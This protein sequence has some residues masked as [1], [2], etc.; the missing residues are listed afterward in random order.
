MASV[1]KVILIGNLGA[2][3]ELRE[4]KSGSVCTIS[5]ATTDTWFDKASNSKKERTEWH[6][7]IVWGK[8][9]ENVHKYLRK[10]SSAYVE[11]RLQTRDWQDKDG[12][13]RWTTEI[14]ANDVRFIGGRDG[15]GQQRDGGPPPS[16]DDAPGGSFS[17]D[18]V[19]F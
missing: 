13:K 10:G 15:G 16:F 17:D 14:V 11:G 3:P 8:Q 4:T 9:G 19:P 12:N 1:N 5:L 2:D 7:V 18:E 6:R